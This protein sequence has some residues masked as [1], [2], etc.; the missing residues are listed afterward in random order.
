MEIDVT[1]RSTVDCFGDPMIG[2][3]GSGIGSGAPGIGVGWAHD[4]IWEILVW[5]FRFGGRFVSF[6]LISALCMCLALSA[7]KRIIS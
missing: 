3:V 5:W 2:I 6:R 7:E 1:E 4:K